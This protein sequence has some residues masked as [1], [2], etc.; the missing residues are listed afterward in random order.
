MLVSVTLFAVVNFTVKLLGNIPFEQ[1]VFWRALQS[2]VI[3]YSYLKW[4][5]MS[6]WGVN[7]RNLIYRGLAGTCALTFFFY[8]LHKLPLA[9]SVTIQY[10][11]PI[12][13]ILIAGMFFGERIRAV[14]W[15]AA[16]IGFA[17]VLVIEGFDPG[18]SWK[19]AAVGVLGALSSAIAY[20][21]V[22][23]LRKT[24]SEWVVV[25]Y[26]PLVAVVVIGPWAVTRWYWPQGLEWLGLL[27]VGVFTQ[28]AQ[29]YMTK[30]YQKDEVGKVATINYFGVVYAMILGILYFGE[31]PTLSTA[32][33]ILLIFIGMWLSSR[34]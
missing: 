8:T 16:L 18:V 24:D 1:V 27:I 34:R 11:A 4:K 14:H 12:F 33:G 23:A 2:L 22:R 28:W 32:I 29:L 13:S 6:P 21:F 15:L 30:A 7:K 9:T 3:S 31:F 26:F 25:F 5:R 19:T 20:N 17:G 10:L